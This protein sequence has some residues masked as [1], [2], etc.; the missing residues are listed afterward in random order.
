MYKLF[1]ENFRKI[2][3]FENHAVESLFCFSFARNLL[4]IENK[5]SFFYEHARRLSQTLNCSDDVRVW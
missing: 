3:D 5:I 2:I 1:S 4:K